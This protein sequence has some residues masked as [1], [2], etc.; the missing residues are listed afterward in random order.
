[1][2]Y[3]AVSWTMVAANLTVN[4]ST[5]AQPFQ[6]TASST[7]YQG[8]EEHEMANMAPEQSGLGDT[9]PLIPKYDDFVEDKATIVQRVK[10]FIKKRA[11]RVDFKRIVVGLG[12]KQANQG[13]AVAFGPKG[14]ETV[15]FKQDGTS[16]ASQ[17]LNS[18][19]TA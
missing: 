6:P 12:K 10:E 17:R 3:E 7:P 16:N 19:K 4:L 2:S 8:G 14:G 15:I 13:K 1:M 5:R 9:V 18:L 11:P